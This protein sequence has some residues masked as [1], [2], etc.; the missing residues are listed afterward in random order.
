MMSV[1]TWAVFRA[2]AFPDDTVETEREIV[3]FPGR[4]VAE[5]L[6]AILSQLGCAEIGAP[7]ERGEHGWEVRFRFEGKPFWFQVSRIEPETLL[8]FQKV[9]ER[10]GIFR[11]PPSREV[12][13][14]QHEDL[15]ARLRA[16]LPSDGRFRDLS[17]YTPQ[18]MDS[19]DWSLPPEGPAREPRG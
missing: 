16:A 2:D 10:G 3:T 13:T 18:E 12:Q 14:L 15:L 17:W 11:R 19:V 6:R 8:L 1:K 4:N 9:V 5:A 7:L